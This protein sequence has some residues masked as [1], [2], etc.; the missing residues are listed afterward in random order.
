MISVLRAK[1]ERGKGKVA[2]DKSYPQTAFALG[3][4]ETRLRLSL[5]IKSGVLSSI[6]VY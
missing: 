4:N 6:S 1:R 3:V 2:E 5:K